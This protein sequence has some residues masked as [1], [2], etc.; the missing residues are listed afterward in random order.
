M[1]ET[2]TNDIDKNNNGIPDWAEER[3]DDQETFPEG[4]LGHAYTSEEKIAAKIPNYRDY[5][6]YKN[7]AVEGHPNTGYF[8]TLGEKIE[9]AIESNPIQ[10][11]EEITQIAEQN[12]EI[13]K[14]DVKPVLEEAKQAEDGGT[15]AEVNN[16][17]VEKTIK[18]L[19]AFL[20]DLPTK[21]VSQEEYNEMPLDEI[22]AQDALAM[23]GEGDYITVANDLGL[24]ETDLTYFE[25]PS[26]IQNITPEQQEEVKNEP[27][28]KK[29]LDL[30]SKFIPV[31]S[32]PDV[33]SAGALSSEES[34]PLSDTNPTSG[35]ST[36]SPSMPGSNGGS[37]ASGG[38]NINTSPIEKDVTSTNSQNAG[39]IDLAIRDED[40]VGS[41]NGSN[42]N[43]GVDDQFD[44][45]SFNE[46]KHEEN[47]KTNDQFDLNGKEGHTA[48]P[49]KLKLPKLGESK[50]ITNDIKKA[51]IEDSNNWG[52]NDSKGKFLPFR[53]IIDGED[54]I[55][56]QIGTARK[57]PFEEF[58]KK[59]PTAIKQIME[60]IG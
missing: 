4:D 37:G 48:E 1:E 27:D 19:G 22:E 5:K 20:P 36:N 10:A 42:A 16:E 14:E 60:R 58:I 7:P 35:V 11:Q 26:F 24:D 59:E 53:F 2:L 33:P 28:K 49:N 8:Y 52:G 3:V 50:D 13:S 45:L 15:D 38:S 12:P 56:A 25:D 54:I 30:L 9:N 44:S 43:K 57:L 31:A 34:T 17:K 6:W 39:T 47:I 32:A 18:K 55:V 41:Q 21:E 46:T 40:N 51:I 23:K 29:K